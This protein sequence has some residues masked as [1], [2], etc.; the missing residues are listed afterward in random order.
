M[1]WIITR[2]Q[3]LEVSCPRASLPILKSTVL[4]PPS[5]GGSGASLFLSPVL[6]G[7]DAMISW[8][9]MASWESC[10]FSSH[11]NAEPGPDSR[12]SLKVRWPGT[13]MASGSILDMAPN[14]YFALLASITIL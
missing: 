3:L 1:S 8:M 4:I 14:L 10:S 11:K 13:P 5:H 2:K 9:W 7:K 6:L 12:I